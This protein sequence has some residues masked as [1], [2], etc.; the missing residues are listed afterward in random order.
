MADF[1]QSLSMWGTE[2]TTPTFAAIISPAHAVAA[3]ANKVAA[4]NRIR[5]AF[6]VYGYAGEGPLS[7][8]E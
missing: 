8:H 6:I 2:K 4:T 7:S 5:V 3:T 1:N